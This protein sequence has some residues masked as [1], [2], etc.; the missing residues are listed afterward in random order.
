MRMRIKCDGHNG[1]G[2]S[3]RSPMR[4][5]ERG[6]TA[7]TMVVVISDPPVTILLMMLKLFDGVY[8]M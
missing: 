4:T 6:T 8:T 3:L 7:A 5:M 2:G 1:Q